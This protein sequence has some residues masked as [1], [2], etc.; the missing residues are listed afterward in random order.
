M[1]QPP[2]QA[3][4][5]ADTAGQGGEVHQ[6]LGLLTRQLHDSLNGLGLADKLKDSAGE[7]PDAKTR[8]GYIARLTGEAAEKVLN[9]VD[10]AKARHEQLKAR[11]RAM[12]A[13]AAAD[14][15]G[16]LA[17]G[18]VLA[19]VQE[20][21]LTAH[22]VDQDL[23]EIMLAQDFHDLTGQVIAKVVQLAA[24][25]EAQLVQLLIQTAPAPASVK[26]APAQGG[27][28]ALAG[29]VFQAVAS[30]DVVTA[31]SEVDALLASLGF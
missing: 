28:S 2:I 16:S 21:E 11:A 17:V 14:P 18:T 7:L 4:G 24:A 26:P 30:A 27:G 29:P 15:A 1:T 5:G 3:G 13:L 12:A 31:Q 22:A 6:R 23:T 9:R 20:V 25:I 19:F 10:Q 8:L